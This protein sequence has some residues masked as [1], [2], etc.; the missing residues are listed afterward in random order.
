MTYTQEDMPFSTKTGM[1][2]D[3]IINPHAIPSR[4]TIGQLLECLFG[5]LGCLEGNLKDSTSFENTENDIHHVYNELKR[6]GYD[7]YGNEM[8][9][10]GMT[11]QVL[12]HAIF[13]GPTYYQRLKHMVDDKIHSRSKGPVQVLTRQPVEGRVRDGGLRIGEMERDAMISH[14]AS[15]FL[16]DRLFYQSD[17]YRVF[18]CSLCGLM[19]VGD[20]VHHK[21]YCSVCNTH[22]VVQVEIPFATKLLYQEL[23]S[24]GITPRIVTH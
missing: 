20:M 5:K 10:N 3:I 14:G 15:S 19:V 13:M 8:L 17:A 18:V 1:T 22:E 9:V 21:Y 4:M 6:R 23:M 24:M 11:G 12:E 2:P 7:S 16:K